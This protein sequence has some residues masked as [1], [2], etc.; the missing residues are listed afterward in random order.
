MAAPI[1]P[2]TWINIH[3]RTFVPGM[4]EPIFPGNAHKTINTAVADAEYWAK[5]GCCV[6]L[7]QGMYR[8]AGPVKGIY[9]SADRTYPNLVSCK[10]LY[11][12]VDVKADGYATTQDAAAAVFSFLKWFGLWPTIIVGSGSGGF[13]LYWT[14][15]DTVD[16]AEFAN[17]ANRLINAG[18]EYGIKFDKQC[19]RDATRLLR[20]AGTFNF[21]HALNGVPATPV[22]LH[23]CTDGQH[24]DV[25]VVRKHLEHWPA[26]VTQ[27]GKSGGGVGASARANV[28]GVDA[29]GLPLDENADLTGGMKKD[30]KPANIE[31]VAQ[32]CAFIKNTLDAG[33]ANLVGDPQWHTVLALACHCIEPRVTAHRLC[34]K[35][36]HY[37][38]EGTDEKFDAAQLARANRETIG[39]PKCATIAIEREECKTCPHYQL[40]TSPLSVGFKVNPQGN[41]AGRNRGAG[42]GAGAGA[43]TNGASVSGLSGTIVTPLG[44]KGVY[45]RMHDYL[46][47]S[48]ILA[49]DE[50]ARKIY[51]DGNDWGEETAVQLLNEYISTNPHQT[52]EPTLKT[53]EQAVFSLSHANKFNSVVDY[54]RGLKWDGVPRIH[55]WLIKYCGAK[56]TALNRHISYRS[57][58]S[59]VMRPLYPGCK[60][61]TML[62]LEG[63]Q[64]RGK[65]SIFFVLADAEHHPERFYDGGIIHENAKEQIALL[66]GC[67][68][69][70][71]AELSDFKRGDINKVNSYLSRRADK[72]RVL[73]TNI[74]II[75]PRSGVTVGTTNDHQY[76]LNAENRRFWCV[77]IGKILLDLIAQDRD[78]LFAEAVA[79]LMS[80][81]G[82]VLPETVWADAAKMQQQRRIQDDWEDVLAD[83]MTYPEGRFN[84]K[85]MHAQW[86]PIITEIS[87]AKWGKVL[88]AKSADIAAERLELQS[89]NMH[90]QTGHRLSKV[91]R[92]LGWRLELI[93]GRGRGYIKELPGAPPLSAGDNDDEDNDDDVISNNITGITR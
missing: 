76:L 92:Q 49:Y 69:A 45:G 27:E 59:F 81:Q 47:S 75:A 78:Q 14:L 48:H 36:P 87:H 33:G 23:A 83:K 35:S 19:T 7:S 42:A 91:M 53:V 28:G 63:K 21:K 52:K 68:F 16:R 31:E 84:M 50:F 93:K 54:L 3:H 4:K 62:T 90:G 30:Y 13:H 34:E 24:I 73:F 70:E 64:G 17:L 6:Y 85:S 8:V 37:N 88:F 79:E 82:A 1:D 58:I 67:W 20:V 72:T 2:G 57:M 56:D 29:H 32:H 46:L 71:I 39:P 61:D 43:S 89:Q 77:R 11:I 38:K 66:Q 60:L 9:P 55:I 74:P 65:S 15:N 18:I 5:R 10:N 51:I 86:V 22:T 25:D 26:T 40:G 80:G 41:S 12:D 44:G